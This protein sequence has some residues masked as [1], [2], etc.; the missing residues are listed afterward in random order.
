MTEEMR[1]RQIQLGELIYKYKLLK[2][3]SESET[4]HDVIEPLVRSKITAYS[5][6]F[7]EDGIYTP[8]AKENSDVAIAVAKELGSLINTVRMAEET[9]NEAETK[10]K[11]LQA[12]G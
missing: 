2:D 12:R 8:S 10:L 4:W 3:F 7:G 6:G 5:G 11:Q 1:Q 9:L